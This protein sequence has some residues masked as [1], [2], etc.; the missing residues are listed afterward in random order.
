VEATV[1]GNDL[2]PASGKTVVLVPASSRRQNPSLYRIAN[3]DAQ[4]HVALANLAPGQ[5]KLF[6][7]DSVPTGAWMN[8]EFIAKVEE[9]GTAVTVNAGARQ[10]A[11]L[12]LIPGN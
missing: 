10:S 3:T 12:K 4:G 6:A 11:Q 1:V 8:A 7:W 9:R 2:K 5:Y